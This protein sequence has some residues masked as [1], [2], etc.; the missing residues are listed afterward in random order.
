MRRG[1]SLIE[2]IVV[3]SIVSLICLIS[4][5]SYKRFCARPTINLSAST[6][7]SE[8]RT[9][10]SRAYSENSTKQAQGIFFAPSGNPLPGKFGTIIVNNS[11]KVIVSNSGR[12]RIE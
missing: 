11:K 8:I 4:L 6:I 10:Q 5:P 7:A 1:F 3:I 9:A 2:L 12:V